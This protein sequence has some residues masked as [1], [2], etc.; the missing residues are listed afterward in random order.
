MT[1]TKASSKHRTLLLAAGAAVAFTS[2]GAF[3]YRVLLPDT[4]P[5]LEEAFSMDLAMTP[6]AAGMRTENTVPTLPN[7][8]GV[9]HD[10]VGEADSFGRDSTYLGLM[11]GYAVLSPT[12]PRAN[13]YPGEKCQV[14]SSNTGY[15]TFN[16]ENIDQIT[17]PAA[18]LNSLMCQWLT[19]IIDINYR[20]GGSVRAAGTYAYTPTLTILNPVLNDPSLI[21]PLTGQ[22]FN[23]KLSTGLSSNERLTVPLEPGF[24]ISERTRKSSVCI[25]GALSRSRLIQVYGLSEAQ[26]DRF[27][28]SPTTVQLNVS[29]Y[30]QHVDFSWLALSMRLMGD[31]RM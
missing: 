22:A 23:G 25:A 18:S 14:I 3:A 27:L 8:W 12:C 11:S 28:A 1:Q 24:A 21:N 17:L 26:A 30:S 16:F 19:P 29:G 4:A 13:P 6:E 10:T 20:N 2:L 7:P 5:P 15:T 9:T 31:A